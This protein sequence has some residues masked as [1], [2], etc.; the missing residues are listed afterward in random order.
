VNLILP[1]KYFSKNDIENVK[2]HNEPK[3]AFL[4]PQLNAK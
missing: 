3:E 2:T 1:S 4:S